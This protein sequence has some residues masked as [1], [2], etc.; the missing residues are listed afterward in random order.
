[1]CS[2]KVSE[3]GFTLLEVL[4]AALIFSIG[5]VA[6]LGAFN[7][8]IFASGNIELAESALN[9]A[10]EK[11]ELIKNSTYANISNETETVIAGFPMFERVVTVVGLNESLKQA[12]V[13]VSWEAR[14]GQDS[15]ILT[16][17]ITD[18]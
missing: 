4:A 1:M 13:A 14:P 9:L 2:R 12:D 10:Q 17:L 18:Y 11:M 5:V 6:L 3:G 7:S 16:T 15:V 8:G